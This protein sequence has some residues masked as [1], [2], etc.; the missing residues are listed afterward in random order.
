MGHGAGGR[1]QQVHSP[2][3]GPQLPSESSSRHCVAQRPPD[4]QD[5]APV[6]WAANSTNASA[7]RNLR[8]TGHLR[9]LR[10]APPALFAHEGLDV[11]LEDA[12][13]F[14]DLARLELIAF[15]LANLILSERIPART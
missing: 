15:P 12:S 13:K 6:T 5:Q 14:I 8:T 2:Q 11:E 7:A 4:T 3:R 9:R 10:S 1:E